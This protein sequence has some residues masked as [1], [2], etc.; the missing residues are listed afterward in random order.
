MIH[1]YSKTF[2]N[3]SNCLY[4]NIIWQKHEEKLGKKDLEDKTDVIQRLDVQSFQVEKARNMMANGVRL[5]G[6]TS[7]NK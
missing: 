5:Q 7:A 6:Q 1:N 3:I 2:K 4:L